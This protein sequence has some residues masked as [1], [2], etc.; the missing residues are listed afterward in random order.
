MTQSLSNQITQVQKKNIIFN[1]ENM[2][3][4]EICWFNKYTV[5]EVIYIKH[6]IVNQKRQRFELE[7]NGTGNK[8]RKIILL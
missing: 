8:F 6:L 1:I 4:S 5:D 7:I 2:K 3:A